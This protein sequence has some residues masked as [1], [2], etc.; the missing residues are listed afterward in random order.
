MS[1]NETDPKSGAAAAGAESAP[2]AA[3]A[4]EGAPEPGGGEAEAAVAAAAAA[5]SELDLARQTIAGQQDKYLRLQAEFENYKKRS[6]REQA[7]QRKYA[8]LPLLTELTAIM[9]N[10]EHALRH[11]GGGADTA[12]LVSGVDL[13]AKQLAAVFER[14]GMTRVKA[15]SQPFDPARHQA[16]SVVETNTVPE[17]QVLEELRAG[18]VLHER[19]VRPAMV[20]VAKKSTG[21]GTGSGTAGEPPAN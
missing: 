1:G 21:N 13:V 7:D 12:A 15:A 18:Y 19:V 6:Q 4:P 10:L 9:D 5:P 16:V 3:A 20:S 2:T 14:F 17:N 11:G 8:Q